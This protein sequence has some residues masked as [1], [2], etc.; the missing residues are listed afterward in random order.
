MSGGYEIL[1]QTKEPINKGK[2]QP[3]Y[4]RNRDLAVIPAAN[5][6]IEAIEYHKPYGAV[7]GRN[8]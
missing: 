4:D 3:M 2:Q 5:V 6:I 1:T 8:I 7:G